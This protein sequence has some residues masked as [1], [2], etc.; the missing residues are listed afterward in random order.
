[1]TSKIKEGKFYF[2]YRLGPNEFSIILSQIRLLDAKRLK[3]KI[4]TLPRPEYDALDRAFD[5]LLKQTT[6][7]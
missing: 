2:R 3:R 7:P 1:V 6:P 4:G 5:A